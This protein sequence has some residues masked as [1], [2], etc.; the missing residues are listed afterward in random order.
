MAVKNKSKHVVSIHK[1]YKPT[2]RAEYMKDRYMN[3]A[4]FAFRSYPSF[5]GVEYHQQMITEYFSKKGKNVTVFT[6]RNETSLEFLNIDFKFPFIHFP[7]KKSSLKYKEIIHGVKYER[8]DIKMRWYSYNRMKGLY[9]TFD[10]EIENYDIIHLHGLNV[11]NNYKLAKIAHKHNV[12]VILSCYDISI[13]DNLPFPTK[14]LKRMYD[15]MFIGRL[16]RYVSEFLLL[17][18]D[19]IHELKKLNID[20]DKIKVWS[21][22]YDVTRYRKKIDPKKAK[23]ILDKYG[24]EAL[25]SEH[26]KYAFNM[27]RIEEYK[28]IQ[29]IVMLANDFP[30]ITFVIAGR[31]H[32][33]LNHLKDMVADKNVNNVKFI[34]EIDEDEATVLLQNAYVFIFPS[35][36]EGWGIVLAEAMSVGVPCVA[37][38]IPNVR[39]VFTDSKSGFLVKDIKE[40]KQSLIKVINNTKLRSTLSKHA[41]IESE[42]YDFHNNLPILEKLYS[43]VLENSK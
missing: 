30:K 10:N 2:T 36:K 11:Y 1:K 14:I 21:A 27:G 26:Q 40:M 18:K 31:D 25:N 41:F 16:N 6:S 3:I 23:K 19:Q 8:F 22:G 28:G 17:T 9:K 37:Y 33:Y 4:S 7:K 42:K 39:T 12:P 32:G 43:K 13:P 34:G 24:L 15:R 5:G 35:K 20:A 29:D 38:D